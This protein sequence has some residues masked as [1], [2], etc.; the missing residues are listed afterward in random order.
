MKWILPQLILTRFPQ[1]KDF[2]RKDLEALREKDFDEAHN[3]WI[4]R[5]LSHYFIRVTYDR[6]LRSGIVSY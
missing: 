2:I 5:N 3:I 4:R 6:N 1:D